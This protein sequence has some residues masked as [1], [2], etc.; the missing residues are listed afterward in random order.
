MCILPFCDYTKAI[1]FII[2]TIIN[3]IFIRTYWNSGVANSGERALTTTTNAF[4]VE[5]DILL[6]DSSIWNFSNIDI[7]ELQS[8]SVNIGPD[9]GLVS[10]LISQQVNTWTNIDPDLFLT[11]SF[12]MLF[13][14]Q[15]MQPQTP[16]VQSAATINYKSPL[17]HLPLDKMDTIS[18]TIFSNA[19]S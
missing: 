12:A 19:F 18:Q 16:S 8:W 11:Y 13:Q 2:I 15:Y 7:T 1:G 17:T 10:S 5:S 6:V 9:N 4:T 3:V 14:L